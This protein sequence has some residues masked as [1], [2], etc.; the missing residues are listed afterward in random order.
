[1]LLL[2]VPVL[3]GLP[4]CSANPQVKIAST[5][6]TAALGELRAASRDFRKAYTGEI[7]KTREEIKGAI[8]A[9]AV[10]LRVEHISAGLDDRDSEFA[11]RGLISL[12]DELKQTEEE[13]G[14]LAALFDTL[15]VR[16][17][18]SAED[19]IQ[20]VLD[21]RVEAARSAADRM[22]RLGNLA[23][24]EELEER[25]GQLAEENEDA[26]LVAYF[27]TLVLLGATAREAGDNLRELDTLVRVLQETHSVIHEWIMT[28]VKVSGEQLA[29]LFEEHAG[30]LGLTPAPPPE[31]PPQDDG[32]DDDGAGEGGEGGSP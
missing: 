9:R 20:R 26:K 24:A 27:E 4:A 14:S 7:R 18:E 3:V 28:D 25:A 5:E 8:V 12:A 15:T 23:V 29:G 11:A 30:T 10:R 22:R 19:G 2:A 17:D 13:Y 16:P 31:G 32:G 21:A 6:F 1:M